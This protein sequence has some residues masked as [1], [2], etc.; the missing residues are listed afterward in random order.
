MLQGYL[1]WSRMLREL[2]DVAELDRATDR[3]ARFAVD[4]MIDA[5]APTNTLLGNPAAMRRA[6]ETGG[7]SVRAGMEQMLDD[8][9]NNEGRPRQVDVSQFELGRDLA[10]SSGSVVFR[11][12]LIELIQYAPTTKTVHAVPLLMSPPWINKYYVM[13]LAP[14]KSFVEWAVKHGHTVFAISYVNPGTEQR[15]FGFD[16]YLANGPLAALDVV[17]AI[18]GAP[19]INV[20]ALCLGGTLA[21][22]AAG[23]M[24]AG[25]DHR[26]GCLTMLNTL[27]D[28]AE[29]GVLGVFADADGLEAV[30]SMMGD[31]GYLDAS[32]MARTFD[33]LRANDLIWNY[34]SSGWLM[35]EPPPA[36]DLLAW[37]ADSTRMPAR[38]HGEYLRT[39]Y[40]EN[41][42]AL[43][44]MRM[45]GRKIALDKVTADT[46]YVAAEQDHITPWMSCYDSSR[47]LGGDVRFVLS[48][49]GHI[50]GIVN[51]PGGRRTF[52][53]NEAKPADAE[54]WLATAT[55]HEGS[56]WDDWAAW[57]KVRGGR[58][59]K[60]PAIG[61]EE[62]PA[63]CD[64]PGEYVLAR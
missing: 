41:Q 22:A 59:G 33:A 42:L 31:K 21:A 45:L 20:A 12:E 11:N 60:P 57:M 28:F 26:L 34:V 43:G 35:G 2:V 40:V 51:P 54:K 27:L 46:Y 29:P 4:A 63:L 37:N 18:T 64:A 38:M 24:A 36:F 13:D 55:A 8:L 48:S 52:R 53:T 14:G 5:L 32:A 1:L 6:F 7:Q 44:R 56:W 39:C 16:D 15:D 9:A 50:A 62:Y 47:L 61:N 10:S 23:W 49:S 58:R 19:K 25:N 30:G 3:K 17:Q